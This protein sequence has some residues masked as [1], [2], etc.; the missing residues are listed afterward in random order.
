M[1]GLWP[2]LVKS[3]GTHNSY[4]HTEFVNICS[5]VQSVTSKSIRNEDG[6]L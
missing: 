6:M 4:M 5:N 2:R 1:T 3:V